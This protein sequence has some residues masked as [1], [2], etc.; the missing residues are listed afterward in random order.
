MKNTKQIWK[1]IFYICLLLYVIN[2]F[3]VLFSGDYMFIKK[4]DAYNYISI[5]LNA[6]FLY[7]FYNFLVRGAF[8][9][10]Y[11][12]IMF[13]IFVLIPFLIALATGGVKI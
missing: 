5:I 6:I 11:L 3:F 12:V 13:C 8:T 9:T 1:I 10:R 4:A 7:T 2:I